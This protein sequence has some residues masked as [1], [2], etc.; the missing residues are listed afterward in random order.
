MS[1][2]CTVIATAE[3]LCFGFFLY[4]HSKLG[5]PTCLHVVLNGL[6]SLFHSLQLNLDLQWP[7]RALQQ[8]NMFQLSHIAKTVSMVST[9]HDM[10]LQCG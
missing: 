2:A 7:L 10:V 4:H 1:D 5:M 9:V 6:Q 8:Y 3:L